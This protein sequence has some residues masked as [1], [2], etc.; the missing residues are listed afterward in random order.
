MLTPMSMPAKLALWLRHSPRI[1][2]LPLRR[3]ELQAHLRNHES[4]IH[5]WRSWAIVSH[6]T[7]LPCDSPHLN[8]TDGEVIFAP[9]RTLTPQVFKGLPHANRGYFGLRQQSS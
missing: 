7:A 3:V 8:D 1:P 4:V 5:L 6:H 9:A 2:D